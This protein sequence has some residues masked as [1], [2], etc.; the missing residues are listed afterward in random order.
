MNNPVAWDGDEVGLLFLPAPGRADHAEM[1][2][3]LEQEQDQLI[4]EMK[5]Q[6]EL[7]KWQA[8]DETKK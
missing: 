3:S 2:P 1:W 7:E 4:A 6:L 5:K 8:V